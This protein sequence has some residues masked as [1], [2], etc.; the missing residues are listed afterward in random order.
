VYVL[1]SYREGMPRTVLEALAVGRPVITTDAPG[2]RETVV[3][4]RNG[5]LVPV[6]D[7][8]ALYVAMLRFARMPEAELARMAEASRAMAEAEF[9]VRRVNAAIIAALLVDA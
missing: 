1:P 6:A 2:C 4:E 7:S 9:D 3:P 5:V 8:D